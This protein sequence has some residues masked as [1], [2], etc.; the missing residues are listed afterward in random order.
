[1]L[2]FAIL[3]PSL[4]AQAADVPD[5]RQVAGNYVTDGERVNSRKGYYVYAYDCSLDLNQ[6]FAAQYI[7]LLRRSGCSLV[8][9]EAKDFRRTSAQYVDKWYFRCR[10]QVVEFWQYQY[11]DQG[12]ISFSV[13]VGHG[14]T[15]AG[16]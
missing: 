1:M 4:Q 11:F 3:I 6:N 16:R 9:H 5:F 10:G 14:L 2:A 8:G 7:N 15:Y 13:R 12:R